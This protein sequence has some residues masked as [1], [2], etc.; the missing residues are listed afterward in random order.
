MNFD[1]MKTAWQAGIAIPAGTATVNRLMHDVRD[2]DR[3]YRRQALARR[4]YGSTAMALALAMLATVPW[5]PGGVW[6]G[7][8]VAIAVWSLSLLACIARLWSVRSGRR[9]HNSGTLA[10]SLAASLHAIHREMAYFRAL[11]WLFWLPFG[12]GFVFAVS[13]RAPHGGAPLFLVL[14]TAG[15][16]VWGMLY[17]PR[18]MLVHLQPQAD[19]LERMLADAHR[20]DLPRSE[21]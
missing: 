16:W 3:R 1:Q 2:A 13:W 11:R 15:L 10:A 20:D 7:M 14:G 8:R 19:A 9:T 18:S 21:A 6:P 17:G 12:I 4:I 5:L